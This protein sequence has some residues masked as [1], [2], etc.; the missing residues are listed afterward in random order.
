VSRGLS[1]RRHFPA[2]VAA[3]LLVA[4]AAT[5]ARADPA[6]GADDEEAAPPAMP[7][8]IARFGLGVTW[9]GGRAGLTIVP[10]VSSR[11]GVGGQLGAFA[12]V[13]D[14]IARSGEAWFVGPVGVVAL[15]KGFVI[16]LGGGY[17]QARG[18]DHSVTM[19][20]R[21]ASVDVGLHWL[22][23]GGIGF[24]PRYDVALDPRGDAPAVGAFT[25]NLEIGPPG[26]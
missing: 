9:I 5:T 22:G 14:T 24:A 20:Y 16:S 4:L 11:F 26:E 21:G 7:P 23:G 2:R 18:Q 25:L 10:R 15:D 1:P 3:A 6:A 13:S 8:L 12:T 19:S 17:A